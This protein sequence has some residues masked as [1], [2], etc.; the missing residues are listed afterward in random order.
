MQMSSATPQLEV[1]RAF[2]EV[3]L[4]VDTRL[5]QAD[6]LDTEK[7]YPDEYRCSVQQKALESAVARLG[8]WMGKT[9]LIR[10]DWHLLFYDTKE[11][12]EAQQPLLGE[13]TLT[14]TL[15]DLYIGSF[16][17]SED[18][19]EPTIICL[20]LGLDTTD[21]DVTETDREVQSLTPIK[22]ITQLALFFGNQLN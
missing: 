3:D 22:K 6:L 11:T 13:G 19:G 16:T 20:A 7:V 8:F 14:G 5:K 15:S 2:L 21:P 9:V 10:S 17:Q 1:P 4:L 12:Y 18:D